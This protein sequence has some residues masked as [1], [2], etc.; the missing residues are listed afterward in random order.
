MAVE[1]AEQLFVDPSVDEALGVPNQEQV[2]EEEEAG[3]GGVDPHH[4]TTLTAILL[5]LLLN[6]VENVHLVYDFLG[7][8]Q[9]DRLQTE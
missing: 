2:S 1:L 7:N 6:Q 3:E 4:R 9:T 5:L 8:F